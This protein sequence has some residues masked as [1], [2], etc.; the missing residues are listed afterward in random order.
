VAT[1]IRR[2]KMQLDGLIV[3]RLGAGN[4]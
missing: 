1:H 4:I 3:A 2:G